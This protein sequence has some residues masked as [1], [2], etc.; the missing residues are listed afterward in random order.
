MMNQ[1]PVS[2]AESRERFQWYLDAWDAAG[3]EQATRQA[4]MSVFMYIAD[5]EE[6]AIAEAKRTVQEHANLF[7]LL[8]Q[9]D[10][11]NE[12]YAGD[13]SV[14][15]FLAP[16]G[17]IVRMFRERTL[18]GTADQVIERIVRYRELGF[19]ELSFLIR[20]GEMS[21]AQAM[22]TMQRFN[23]DVLPAFR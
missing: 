12:D 21:H 7:R 11:W 18:I 8:F 10:Q 4:M 15:E 9:G 1:Y 13:E 16:D 14:F 22:T 20:T 5:S 2:P 23:T 6:Q 17:D 19:T 3:H